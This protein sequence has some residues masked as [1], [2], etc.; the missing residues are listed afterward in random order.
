MSFFPRATLIAVL[1]VMA[2]A[3]PAPAQFMYG[4]FGARMGGYSPLPPG[5]FGGLRP[6][7]GIAPL[8]GI[9]GFNPLMFNPFR[10]SGYRYYPAVSYYYFNRLAGSGYAAPAYPIAGSSAGYFGSH[11]GYLTGGVRNNAVYSYAR[12][13]G[14]AQHEAT[15]REAIADQWAYEQGARPKTA[16]TANSA[17][18]NVKPAPRGPIEQDITS[19]EALNAALAGIMVAQKKGGRAVSGYVPP[20]LLAQIQYAGP[21]AA[22][23]LNLA[24]QAGWLELPAAFGMTADL[25]A[26]RAALEPE[27]TAVAAAVQSG[28]QPDP[29]QVARLKA[30]AKRAEVALAPAIAAD[31]SFEDAA[32]AKHLLNQVNALVKVAADPTLSGLV[33]PRW[34]AE[35]ATAGDLIH[36]M[37]QFKLR[38]GPAPAGGEDAYVALYQVLADYHTSLERNVLSKR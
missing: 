31:L 11:S 7:A 17:A 37:N 26:A 8:P 32:A 29:A 13:F 22:D 24:R 2:A 6:L 27:L 21:P 18:Q 16:T 33:N 9:N 36:Q 38:F 19:G 1:G 3:S 14:R 25:R 23:A 34:A 5:L 15:T 10:A 4:G 35:G 20:E 30:A 12:D 28:R